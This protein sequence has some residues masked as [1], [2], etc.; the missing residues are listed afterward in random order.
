MESGFDLQA[1][2]SVFVGGGAGLFKHYVT[3]QD[4]LC[5]LV[6]LPD[7]NLNAVGFERLAGQMLKR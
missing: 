6:A 7:V 4:R 2:P 1:V 5:R 3:P